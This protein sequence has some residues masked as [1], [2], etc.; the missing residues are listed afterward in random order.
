MASKRR[1]STSI[2]N[3]HLKKWISSHPPPY[4]YRGKRTPLL[5]ATQVSVQ[6]PHFM[7]FL[8]KIKKSSFTQ[9]GRYLENR[10]RDDFD[11]EG[12]SIKV[13]FRSK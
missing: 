5:Y 12:T 8:G 6:P 2:L 3:E 9:Y 11:Y 10:I 7:F 4:D 13:S 1:I